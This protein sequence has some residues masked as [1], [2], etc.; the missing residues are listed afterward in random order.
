MADLR[1]QGSAWTFGD[2]VDT[3]QIVSGQFLAA[4]VDEQGQH[5]FEAICPEFCRD[6]KAGGIIVAG[7]NFGCGSS[8]ESAPDV[9][10]HVGVAAVVAESFA[11][12][13]FRN[14][15]AIGLPVLVCPGVA[16]TVR[17]GDQ[18]EVDLERARVT[19]AVSGKTLQA[20]PL[21]AIMLECLRR[22]GIM[23]LLSDP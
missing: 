20:V 10:K 4:T 3:D 12:I 19:A 11:R 1:F 9:L 18:V 8:R 13:F 7:S 5:V 6:F 22:G 16:A 21:N 14:A 2:Q 17:R 23:K 15:I